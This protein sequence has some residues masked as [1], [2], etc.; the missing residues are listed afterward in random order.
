MINVL[1][2]FLPKYMQGIV[3]VFFFY[4]ILLRFS[5]SFRFSITDTKKHRTFFKKNKKLRL[6]W[7]LNTTLRGETKYYYFFY[8]FHFFVTKVL[9]FL[10]RFLVRYVLIGF[11]SWPRV[12]PRQ[13]KR[14]DIINGKLKV[15]RMFDCLDFKFECWVFL[16]LCVAF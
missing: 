3:V 13:D 15:I 9:D 10:S 7:I 2:L 12:A 11:R 6:F 4:Y 1:F 5:F 14:M 8:I 16:L